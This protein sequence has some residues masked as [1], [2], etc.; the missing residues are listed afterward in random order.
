MTTWLMSFPHWPHLINIIILWHFFLDTCSLLC[1]GMN[2]IKM[3]WRWGLCLF[4]SLLG[5]QQFF[6]SERERYYFCLIMWLPAAKMPLAQYKHLV[7]T[8]FFLLVQICPPAPDVWEF[9]RSYMLLYSFLSS[10][11]L[12]SQNGLLKDKLEE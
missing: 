2:T 6:I 3:R 11:Y 10:A 4:V 1:W 8:S 5:L 7:P 9:L 12:S